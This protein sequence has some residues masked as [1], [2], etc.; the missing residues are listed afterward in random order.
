[1]EPTQGSDTLGGGIDQACDVMKHR[2][3]NLNVGDH[4]KVT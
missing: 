1:M 4:R 2:E 3:L